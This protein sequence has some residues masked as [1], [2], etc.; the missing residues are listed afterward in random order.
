MYSIYT[1]KILSSESSGNLKTL[2]VERAQQETRSFERPVL[3]RRPFFRTPAAE[4]SL[5]CDGSLHFNHCLLVPK[6]GSPVV[7]DLQRR[8]LFQAPFLHQVALQDVKPRLPVLKHL[9]QSE[10]LRGRKWDS[11]KWKRRS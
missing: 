10:P 5:T 1:S 11:W 6:D 2:L 7:D 3:P 4:S 9:L 8:I